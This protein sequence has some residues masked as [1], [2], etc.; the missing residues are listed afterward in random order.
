MQIRKNELD[1]GQKYLAHCASGYR[2]KIAA[3][4]L[5]KGGYDFKVLAD[6]WK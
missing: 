4:M 6:A 1:R 2:S 5:Q 3:T